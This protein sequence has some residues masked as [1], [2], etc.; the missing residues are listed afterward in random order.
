MFATGEW[1]IQEIVRAAGT[2]SRTLRH[3]DQIGL[4]EPSRIGNNGYRYYDQVS[5]VSSR[6]LSTWAVAQGPSDES[7]GTH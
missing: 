3:Y 1:S 6:P 2:T 5:L 7:E 4:L